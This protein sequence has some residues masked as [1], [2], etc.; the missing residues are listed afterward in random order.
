[1]RFL[2]LRR[3]GEAGAQRMAAEGALAF[4]L[5][6]IAA[7]TGGDRG[8]LHEAGDVFVGEPLSGDAAVFARDRSEQRAMGD[9]SQPHPGFEQATGQ[10]SG[11]EPRPIST[12]R[13]PVLPLMVSSAPPS[14]IERVVLSLARRLGAGIHAAGDPS[15]AGKISIQPLP[16]SLWLGPRS[17]PTISERRKAP[18]KPSA[19]IA[20]SRNPRRSISSVASIA[21]SSSAKIAS[22]GRAG[23]NACGGCR[24]ARWRCAGRGCPAVRRAGDSASK[25]QT[26]AARAWRRW[27]RPRLAHARYSPTVCGLGGRGSKP[28]RRSQEENCRQSAS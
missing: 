28:L 27:S 2:D 15:A 12:S 18:A 13:Q 26:N 25:S 14:L 19:R 10:V 23:G 5:G 16:S 3:R 20:E 9:S 8:F 7:N 17:R 6:Q 21:S 1:M 24:R 11:L 22:F 4:A